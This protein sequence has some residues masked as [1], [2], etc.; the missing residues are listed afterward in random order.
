MAGTRASRRL[1]GVAQNFA[2]QLVQMA[3][4]WEAMADGPTLLSEPDTGV[5]E[6]DA[7]MA[8]G[9]VNG[10]PQEPFMTAY[11]TD[12]VEAELAR[13]GLDR[14]R[15]ISARIR[16]EYAR[17]PRDAH[18]D[19]ADLTGTS[20]VVF[21]FGEARASFSNQQMLLRYIKVPGDRW[22]RSMYRPVG[23][24]KPQS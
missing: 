17:T 3:V 19:E 18:A 15:L 4:G 1:S 9:T 13:T 14:S 10:K 8:T 22:D 7:V 20:H 24:S 6:I 23:Q 12:W 11:L 16:A 5:I 2:N 21:E